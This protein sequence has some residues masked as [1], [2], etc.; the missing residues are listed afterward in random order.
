MLNVNE[1]FFSLLSFIFLQRRALLKNL[2]NMKGFSEKLAFLLL[3]RMQLTLLKL[4]Q[5][6]EYRVPPIP[7]AIWG[8]WACF[9]TLGKV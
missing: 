1:V 8:R 7:K 6:E 5:I 4:I 3:F 9:V 2:V